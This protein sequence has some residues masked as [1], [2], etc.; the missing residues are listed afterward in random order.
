MR[1]FGITTDT[2]SWFIG[3]LFVLVAIALAS[4]LRARSKAKAVFAAAVRAQIGRESDELDLDRRIGE[5][6]VVEIDSVY[7]DKI[8]VAYRQSGVGHDILCLHG[9]GASM[10]IYRRLAPWLSNDHRVTCLDFPGFGSSEKPRKLSYLLDEQAEHLSRALRALDLEQP[11]IV[12]SSMGAAIAL[13]AATLSPKL[14]RGIVA[15]GPAVDPR[16]IP[17]PLLPLAKHADRLHRINSLATVKAVVQQVISRR[18]LITPALVALYQEPFRDK[19]DSSSAFM[20]AFALLADG[21]M[22]MLFSKLEMPLLIIR[23]LRDRL[24]KQAACEDLHRLVKNSQLITHPTAGHHIM[25]DE[26]EFTAL[27]IRKFDATLV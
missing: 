21:R 24:V 13:A 9:I 14:F 18:E 11:L 10:M 17:I 22:P 27:E 7:G 23:G 26:P 3:L 2:A 6:K 25:E 20:K 5:K 8:S 12:A 1:D 19:G 4:W 15:L 16:R